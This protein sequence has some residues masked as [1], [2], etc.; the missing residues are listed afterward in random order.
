MAANDDRRHFDR[1][2]AWGE[3]PEMTAL[4]AMMW[5]SEADPLLRSHGVVIKLLDG[6]PD[7][8]RLVAGHEWAIRRVP[9]LRHRV[10]D[11][12]SLLGPPAWAESE[13]D[14]EHHLT[15]VELAGGAT[16]DDVLEIAGDMLE[17]GLER[18]R[19]QWRAVL[20]E[21]LPEGQ[22]AYVLA[23][24]HALADG[25]G[26]MQLFDLLHSDRPE[27]TEKKYTPPPPPGVSRLSEPGLMAQHA[28][29]A[30]TGAV[31][32]A[33]RFARQVAETSFQAI[34]A[35]EATARFA[36]SLARVT[37]SAPGTQS[38]LL[39]DRGLGRRLAIIDVGVAEMRRAG[40]AAEGT[41]NDAF[42]AGLLGGLRRYHEAHG[43]AVDELPMA[44]PVSLRTVDEQTGGNRFAGARIAG[45]VG[46][47]DPVERMRAVRERV[48]AAREE[49]ALDFMGITAGVVSR[50]PVPVLT[51]LTASFT[52][53]IDLQAS[54]FRGLSRPSYIAGAR[55]LRIF[56]FGPAPGCGLMATLASHEDRCCI[57]LTID[58]EAFTD[59]DG[60]IVAMG[61]AFDEVVALEPTAD[62][63][64]PATPA[65]AP[66]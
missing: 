66:G 21:G 18:D 52:C 19:P 50:I 44:L 6:A 51:R 60:L 37:A 59:P 55:V 23:L 48:L 45:P 62:P 32:N 15:R 10:V 12:P 65:P 9:R 25:T 38:P 2:T 63:A 41:L 40:K 43:V 54:N 5:R 7:W 46:T 13:V 56:P 3:E 64:Q 53:S 22:A 28:G 31:G 26:V 33:L 4:E 14:L 47:V 42:L 35:P 16:F 36:A 34:T 39:T 61:D 17:E 20:V 57:G 29:K 58:T 11:D 1:T 30:V 27:P 49:P 8:A 24:H